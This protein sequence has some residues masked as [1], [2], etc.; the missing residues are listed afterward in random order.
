MYDTDASLKQFES[1]ILSYLSL[2]FPD[3]YH[4]AILEHKK[5]S[6]KFMSS[7][8]NDFNQI[9][10]ER[11][12][13]NLHWAY[14]NA[15]EAF[16]FTE[17]K[18]KTPST[19]AC[20][21]FTTYDEV[22]QTVVKR[23]ETRVNRFSR[24]FSLLSLGVSLLDIV[25]SVILILIVTQIAHEAGYLFETVLLSTIFIAV[26]AL[27]KVSLDRFFIIP[28]IDRWG[29][30]FYDRMVQYTRQELIK[31]NATF[32]VLMESIVRNETTEKRARIIQRQQREIL[33]RRRIFPTP[34]SS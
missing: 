27:I 20:K 23:A 34:T 11:E 9:H 30:Q 29:W 10:E 2:E 33:R 1:E 14:K 7:L 5:E 26:V 6:I 8:F 13:Y 18:R 24:I 28:T 15:N 25:I 22:A 21:S 17:L 19:P 12:K 31:L 16:K 32:L 4:K 3:Y